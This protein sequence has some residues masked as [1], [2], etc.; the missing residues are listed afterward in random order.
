[1]MGSGGSVAIIHIFINDSMMGSG[2]SVTII[3]IFINDSGEFVE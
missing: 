1:M 3:H 2:G